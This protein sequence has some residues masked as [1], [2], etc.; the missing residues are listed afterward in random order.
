[1]TTHLVV[2]GQVIAEGDGFLR[3]HGTYV[4]ILENSERL[5]ASVAGRVERVNKL[6]SVIPVASSLYRGHVGDLIVGRILEVQTN[7]WKVQISDSHRSAQLPLSGVHLPGGVQRVRTQQDSREMRQLFHEGDLVSAEVHN[8]Q[9]DGTLA[10]HTRSLRYGKLENGCLIIVPP[11]LVA[12]RKNHFCEIGN[13]S[14]LLGTNGYIWI[15]R[16]LPNLEDAQLAEHK[17]KLKKEHTETP[18]L[19]DER[20]KIAR[21]RNSIECLAKVHLMVTPERIEQ[22]FKISQ[23]LRTEEILFPDNIIKLTRS[24]LR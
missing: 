9:S 21:I 6:V 17:E 10:L 16:A 4:E 23:S 3:G 14:L 20:E 22:V 19:P 13:I 18:V 1:M 12:K 7:R 5:V 24:I 11:A 8:V 15:Q 2:P